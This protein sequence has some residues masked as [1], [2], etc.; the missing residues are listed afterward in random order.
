MLSL[1]VTH[2]GAKLEN[3]LLTTGGDKAP[4]YDIVYIAQLD[5]EN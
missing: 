4:V 2:S 5:F 3:T 1:L